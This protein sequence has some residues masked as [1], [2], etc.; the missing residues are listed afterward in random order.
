MDTGPLVA[1]F[2]EKDKHHAWATEVFSMITG[3][4]F[5]TEPVITEAA[6][7]LRKY[8]GDCS[9]L[10]DMLRDG[11]LQIQFQLAAAAVE[12]NTLMKKYPNM[13]LA[14]ASLVI[15]AQNLYDVEVVTVDRKD[16]KTYRMFGRQAIPFK[17]PN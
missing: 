6:Y 12:I 7:F 11:T 8:G 2:N 14:D 16:F 9:G 17:A 4:V 3:D 5:T 1:F 13:D 10:L 15:G